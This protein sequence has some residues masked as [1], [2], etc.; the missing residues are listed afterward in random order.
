MLLNDCHPEF[1]VQHVNS[2][3]SFYK[4]LV[5][6]VDDMRINCGKN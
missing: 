2:K 6:V 1:T 3:V 5:K 4:D